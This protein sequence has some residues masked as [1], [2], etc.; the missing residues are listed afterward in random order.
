MI[1]FGGGVIGFCG[2]DFIV[3]ITNLFSFAIVTNNDSPFVGVFAIPNAF[4]P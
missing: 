1:L 2:L 3:K 4:I